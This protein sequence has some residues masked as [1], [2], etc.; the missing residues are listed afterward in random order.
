VFR[1]VAF[2]AVV[3]L[4]PA[5]TSS[6]PPDAAAAPASSSTATVPE[7]DALI[8]SGPGHYDGEVIA[9]GGIRRFI[10]H[11]PES[12]VSPAPLVFVFH[13]FTGNPDRIEELSEMTAVADREGFAVV[14]PA[15]LGLLPA[16]NVDGDIWSD[17]DVGFVR[18]VASTVADAM[19]V[20]LER[21]YAAGMS[22]GGGM[23]GRLACDAADLFAAIASVAGAH[24]TAPCDPSRPV[25]IAAFHGTSDRIVPYGGMRVL[26]LP[27][28]EEWM[29]GWARRN[30][31]DDLPRVEWVTDGVERRSWS[32]CLADVVLYTIIGGR[33]GWPGSVRAA[34]MGDSTTALSASD[35]IWVFFARHSRS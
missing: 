15:A 29:L 25:P 14:Y 23:A 30:G 4:L 13:G 2:V 26:G 19:P 22:N 9:G 18:D 12:V 11:V 34:E 3:A 1:I 17:A 35:V 33:H 28:V 32:G 6:E 24:T 5:C 20:D 8:V 27:A 21:V 16:W 7:V 10:L 31:C